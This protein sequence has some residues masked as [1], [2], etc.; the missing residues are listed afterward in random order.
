MRHEKALPMAIMCTKDLH[1]T[2]VRKTINAAV[3]SHALFFFLHTLLS[4]SARDSCVRVGWD[5]AERNDI[6][7]FRVRRSS[8]VW[9]VPNDVISDKCRILSKNA[10]RP[11]RNPASRA[12]S[13]RSKSNV[14]FPPSSIFI[15]FLETSRT[16]KIKL[17]QYRP[18][19]GK[20]RSVLRPPLVF[21]ILFYIML[22]V[23]ANSTT[24]L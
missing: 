14:H 9:W 23:P 7:I 16:L 1:R 10:S 21:P 6:E 17:H 18:I 15:D 11:A 4:D 13:S 3:F 5:Q 24:R 20:D 12:K 22:R 19:V 2:V 8:S